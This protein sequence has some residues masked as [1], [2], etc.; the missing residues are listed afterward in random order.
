MLV[1][2]ASSSNLRTAFLKDMPDTDARVDLILYS[3]PGDE[4]QLKIA[5]LDITEDAHRLE[6]FAPSFNYEIIK[7]L[8]TDDALERAESFLAKLN[9][10][11][12]M[13]LREVFTRDGTLVAFE[14]KPVYEPFLYPTTDITDTSYYISENGV[15]KFI[16]RQMRINRPGISI[17]FRR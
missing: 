12:H 10:Y 1:S 11:S 14:A 2:C 16:V 13:E 15:V 6:P 17:N 4:A 3:A 9:G 7:D 5:V 8:S